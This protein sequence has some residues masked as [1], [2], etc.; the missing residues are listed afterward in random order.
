MIWISGGWRF[1]LL[2]VLALAGCGPVYDGP[3]LTK[4]TGVVTLD[5]E[6]LSGAD[7]LLI[8][9]GATQGQG[10][11]GRTDTSGQFSLKS[12][13]GKFEGVVQG[14]YRVVINKLVTPDG[15]DFVA[16]PD[17]DPMTAAYREILPPIYSDSVQTTLTAQ[18]G[19][20]TPPVAFNLAS[21]PH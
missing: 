2:M 4:I 15:A 6:P 10:G 14:N 7:V 16:T 21:E 17:I 20:S 12:P 3:P 5:G 8:P 1:A 13:D 18:I 9:Q 11:A 19:P